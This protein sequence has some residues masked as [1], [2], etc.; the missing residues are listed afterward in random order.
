MNSTRHVY[1][2]LRHRGYKSHRDE[3]TGRKTRGSYPKDGVWL[4]QGIKIAKES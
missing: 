3:D 2:F 1:Q 4:K